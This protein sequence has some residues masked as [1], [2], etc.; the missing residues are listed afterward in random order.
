MKQLQESLKQGPT[1]VTVKDL[2]FQLEASMVQFKFD[3]K[4]VHHTDYTP[5]VIEPSFGIGRILYAILEH[6]FQ[7]REGDENRNWLSLPSCIAPCTCSV[8]PISNNESFD[9]YIQ[10]IS[11]GLTEVG[12]SHK[13][14]DSSGSIGKRYARTDE[15]AIPFGITIDF[16]TLKYDSVTM[17]ERN[18]MKQVRIPLSEIPEVAAGLIAG[19]LNWNRVCEKYPIFTGQESSSAMK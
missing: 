11:S 15:I 7:G 17:R 5:G 16:D 19:R 18:S 1:A 6:N 3:N 12:V 4:M 8:L 13:V 9:P 2:T 14:D 10:R